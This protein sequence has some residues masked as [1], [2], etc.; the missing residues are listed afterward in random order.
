MGGITVIISNSTNYKI[1]PS[2]KYIRHILA[3]TGINWR[4]HNLLPIG[5][6]LENMATQEKARVRFYVP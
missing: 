6:Y 2:R 5:E 1:A 3:N 4:I